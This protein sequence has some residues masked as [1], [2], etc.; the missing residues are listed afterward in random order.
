MPTQKLITVMA[1]CYNEEDNVD[2]LYERVRRVFEALPQYR[3]EMILID[4]AS[5][6]TTADHLRALAAADERVKVIFNARNF[7]HIR[8]PYHAMLQ[9]RGDAVICI[10]SDLQDPPEI[11]PQ[12]LAKWEEGFKAVVGVKESSEESPFFFFARR[13]YYKLVHRLADVEI[14]QNATGSGLYDQQFVKLCRK[15]KDPYPYFRGLI[16]EFG[17]PTA[18]VPYRQ[19]V[20]K[21]G[22]TK[23]N[24]YSLYDIAMLGLTNHSKVP[25]RL[26]TMLGFALAFLSLAVSVVYLIYKLLFWQNFAVGV[27]PV[28]IGLFLF[29][30]VQLFFI[31]VLGEYIGAIHT[32][33]LRRP[34]V[35]EK[36]RLNFPKGEKKRKEREGA[37][38]Y[39]IA[40][41]L[42]REIASTTEMS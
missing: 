38:K 28:V 34:H 1:G 12:F 31:G 8:S 32:Q 39:I 23:N 33:V 26:A 13:C 7:G 22:L 2:E 16:S 11:I 3:W 35:I 17:L 21:R 29:C 20:R 14:I 41:P 24:F 4:N 5:T 40:A 9:A 19:P 42:E 36:E 6:D 25:L 18:R 27:A 15:L 10:V 37:E 30:S